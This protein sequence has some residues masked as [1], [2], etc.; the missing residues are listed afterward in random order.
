MNGSSSDSEN[1]MNDKFFGYFNVNGKLNTEISVQF[2][3]IQMIQIILT[4]EAMLIN[5]SIESRKSCQCETREI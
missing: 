4:T 3:Q 1:E 2:I 5:N